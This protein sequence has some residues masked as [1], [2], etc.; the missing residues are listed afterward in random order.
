MQGNGQGQDIGGSKGL[1]SLQ[2]LC[3]WERVGRVLPK[4]TGET[5]GSC[6]SA[7]DPDLHLDCLDQAGH[8]PNL[9]HPFLCAGILH[10]MVELVRVA[11]LS[12]APCTLQMQVEPS[13]VS[14]CKH[15]S[16]TD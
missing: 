10:G 14:L 11:L 1:A 3:L 4:P 6:D 7:S 9:V 15:G 8:S 12:L 5:L 13:A 16:G 2:G